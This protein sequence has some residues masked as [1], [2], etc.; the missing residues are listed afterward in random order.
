VLVAA[1]CL[2]A[3]GVVDALLHHE[4][5][6][7][8]DERFYE[9]MAIHPTGPHNFPYAYRIALPR[10]V[11]IL[12]FSYVASFTALALLAIAAAGGALY[13]LLREFE[14]PVGYSV[15][16]A[17]GFCLAPNLLVVLVR[18]GRS[19]DAAVLLVLVLGTLFIVRRQRMGLAITL[20]V[21][22]GV[23]E[24]CLFLIPFAYAVWA[25]RP[26]DAAA[27]R[28]T[29]L[30]GTPALVLYAVLRTS[31]TAVG[32]QYIPGYSG[33]FL[34]AR[35]NIIREGL[36]GDDLIQQPRR[37]I[38]AYG[39][40]WLAAPPA[41]RFSSFARRG[42]VLV[43]LC[44]LSMTYAFG[45]GRIIFFAAPVFYVAAGQV[46]TRHRRWAPITLAALIAF[47]LAYAVY[48]QLHGVQ[49][50]I[51]STIGPSTQVPAY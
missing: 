13:A 48:L 21:G 30:V 6:L 28:D 46:L 10:L 25:Q 9:R 49:H 7:S 15:S 43:G 29:L 16:L 1:L 17:V 24:S 26:L 47:D 34:Q 39:P 22:A 23:H 42:L 27:A 44:V 40:L 2:A 11:H 50:G 14:V 41:L 3:A 5:G 35:W 51:N 45:W 8:G 38:L 18:H 20:L 33:S 31:I 32:S 12:P 37:L 36:S 4:A 19:V